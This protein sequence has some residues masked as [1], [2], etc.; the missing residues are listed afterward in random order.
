MKK[1][2]AYLTGSYS[3][4]YRN[5]RNNTHK[6]VQPIVTNTKGKNT[7]KLKKSTELGT[8]DATA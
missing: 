2:V 4:G 8:V 6:P 7:T 3:S 5:I 1:C